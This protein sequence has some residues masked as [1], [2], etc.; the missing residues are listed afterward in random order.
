MGLSVQSKKHGNSEERLS[1]VETKRLQDVLPEAM[2]ISSNKDSQQESKL[3]PFPL[4]TVSP[5]SSEFEDSS[6][7]SNFVVLI[8]SVLSLTPISALLRVNVSSPTNVWCA[9]LT[10]G[11][12]FI[13]EDIKSSRSSV[14]IQ[15]MCLTHSSL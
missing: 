5:L 10:P 8:Y 6:K 2:P 12:Q 1:S 4:P 3:N 7:F 14:F 9:A 13:P 15:G 11:T